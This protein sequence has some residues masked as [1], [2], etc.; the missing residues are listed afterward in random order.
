[1][2]ISEGKEK[3]YNICRKIAG[4]AFRRGLPLHDIIRVMWV[5]YDRMLGWDLLT[6]E[7]REAL[8]ADMTRPA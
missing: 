3:L 2:T 8:I 7:A 4:V 6:P 5:E 1:M